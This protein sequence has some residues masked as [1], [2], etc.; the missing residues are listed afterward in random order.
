M[1]KFTRVIAICA[2]M[3]MIM[4]ISL[5]VTAATS[6]ATVSATASDVSGVSAQTAGGVAVSVTAVTQVVVADAQKAAVSLVGQSPAGNA[7][8]VQVEKVFNLT[9]TISGPTNITINVPGI[10]AGQNIAVIHQR[11]DGVW[12]PVAVV[13]V[14]AGSVT[15]TFNSLSPVAII[16]YASP[17]TGENFAA[18]GIICVVSMMGA[19][20]CL[21][22]YAM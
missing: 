20:F 14:S 8:T 5:T 11:H 13:S 1:K 17:K 18:V 7:A 21:K 9:A 15:A 2:A 6:T 22:K 19:A 4:G 10:T 12:E 3:V 16:S